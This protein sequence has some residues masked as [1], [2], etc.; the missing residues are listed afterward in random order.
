M[1]NQF[2]NL[3]IIDGYF[4]GTMQVKGSNGDIF[5]VEFRYDIVTRKINF[6]N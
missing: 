2:T 5:G 6:W 4:S 3:E 1:E